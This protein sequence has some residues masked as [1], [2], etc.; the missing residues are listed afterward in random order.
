MNIENIEFVTEQVKSYCAS[1]LSEKR[2]NHSLRVAEMCAEIAELTGYDVKK[3]Y[4]AGIGHDIC[5]ELSEDEM[6]SLGEKSGYRISEEE[7]KNV[8]LVHGKA[9][10]YFLKEKFNIED[11]EILWAV[12]LHVNGSLDHGPLA[13]ILFLADKNERGRKHVN[14]EYLKDLFSKSLD[15]MFRSAYVTSINFLKTKGYVIYE[16]T[17]LIVKQLGLEI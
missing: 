9:G 14:E 10:A 1:H 2:Y 16:D 17:A 11:E 12:A 3:A 15:E 7:R 5:K 8:F 6:L 4:L 13:K